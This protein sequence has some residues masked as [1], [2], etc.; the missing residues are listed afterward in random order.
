MKKIISLCLAALI[1]FCMTVPALAEK[2][3]DGKIIRVGGNATVSLAADTA[4]LQIGV[5]T[6]NASVRKAQQEN[7]DLMAAVM[8]TI[9]DTGVEEK[10]VITNQ[11]NVYSSF[12]YSYDAL[13]RET[14]TW[15]YEVSNIVTVVIHDLTLI[16]AVL[17]AAVEAGANTTYGISFSSTQA[18]EA[19]QKALTRAVQDAMLKAQVIAA[20]AGVELGELV[21]INAG[22]N[23]YGAMDTYGVMNSYTYEAKAMDRGTTIVSGDVSVSAEVVLEYR[24]Q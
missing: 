22:Q 3:S 16:G 24:F 12:D 11:F 7:A 18:N 23:S 1:L 4:S 14:R 20:A 10:D 2:E 13:G 21:F 9:L 15:Y 19:Y 17:D 5:T 8:D 6:R